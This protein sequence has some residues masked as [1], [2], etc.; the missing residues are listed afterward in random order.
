MV[1]DYETTVTVRRNGVR[2][3]VT[4]SLVNIASAEP[5]GATR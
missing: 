1:A 4:I 3:N 5:T 2:R